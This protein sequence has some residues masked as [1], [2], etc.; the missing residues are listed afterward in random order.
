MTS[1][2]FDC[3]IVGR[4]ILGL[5]HALAAVRH[6]LRT[7]VIDREARATGASIRDFGLLVVTGQEAGLARR[8]AWRSRE[9]W[10]EIA[11]P[12]GILIHQRGLLMVARR[13]E[14]LAVVEEFAAGPM[15]RGC[16][17][18]RGKALEALTPPLRRRLPGALYSPHE[19]RVESRDAIPRLATWLAAAHGVGFLPP[20][21]VHAVE[22]GRAETALGRITARYIIVCPGLDILTLFPDA[23]ANRNVTLCKQHMLRLAAPGWRLPAPMMSDLALLHLPGYADCPGLPALRGSVAAEQPAWLADGIHLVAAQS[24]DGTIIVGRSQH[25]SAS[26]DPFQPRE[27][28]D[29]ILAELACVIDLPAAEV[30]ERWIG[31]C[32]GGPQTAF[33]D[34]PA[35]NVRLVN[36]TGGNG[37]S[38]AFA[39]AEETVADLLGLPPPPHVHETTAY[40]EAGRHIGVTAPVLAQSTP[41]TGLAR[42]AGTP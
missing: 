8:R 15:G 18:L 34:T 21:V 9:V 13:R 12:A 33:S 19:L 7:A 36:V 11:G 39:I 3:L 31:V 32:P 30:V 17:V 10:A 6:G 1:P 38:T 27:V 35:P 16:R 2:E 26:P 4:G 5:A 29:R 40:D 42:P 37:T 20:A 22:P 28:D 24:A 23:H 25:C 14:S 41:C